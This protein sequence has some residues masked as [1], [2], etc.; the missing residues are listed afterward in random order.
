MFVVPS[1]NRPPSSKVNRNC[2]LRDRSG[3]QSPHVDGHQSLFGGDS[4]HK[5]FEGRG[6][7]LGRSNLLVEIL[8]GA[9][10]HGRA[11]FAREVLGDQVLSQGLEADEITAN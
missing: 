7:R 6:L 10:L 9:G 5:V 3:E 4:L 8:V 2:A 1:L 11:C